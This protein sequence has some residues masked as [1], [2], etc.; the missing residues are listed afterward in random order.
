MYHFVRDFTKEEAKP[1]PPDLPTITDYRRTGTLKKSWHF[2]VKA[3]PGLIVGQVGS[4]PATFAR[5][6]YLPR[7]KSGRLGKPRRIKKPYARYVMGKEQ[8]RLMKSRGWKK[9][10]DLLKEI[11]P[12][13]VK[14]F[15]RVINRTK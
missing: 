5:A 12:K 14:R 10:G 8:S 15:Q 4:D 7:L 13:Q 1:Y 2:L 11:W 6:Y 9:I 3:R